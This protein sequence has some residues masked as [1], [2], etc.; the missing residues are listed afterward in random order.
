M[1]IKDFCT[2]VQHIGLPTNDLAKTISFYQSLGFTTA[3][4]TNNQGE[5]VAF[6]QLHNLVIETYQNRQAS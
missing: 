5:E 3:Y 4:R 1:E 2:G 6:L